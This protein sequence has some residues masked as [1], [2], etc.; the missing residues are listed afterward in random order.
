M[1]T[2]EIVKTAVEALRDKKAEDVTVI[3]ITGVSS[4]ADY[5]IIAN[6]FPK[7]TVCSMISNASGEMERS[8]RCNSNRYFV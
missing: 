5:F 7:K 8:L 2:L 3:D 4:I 1:E 6:G